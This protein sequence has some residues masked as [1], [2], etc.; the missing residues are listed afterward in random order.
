M[1]KE[2]THTHAM[3]YQSAIQKN[4]IMTFAATWMQFDIIILNEISH[5]DKDK[6]PGKI[7]ITSDTQMT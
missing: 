7:S 3:E 1:D 6:L 4:E 2:D 5:K